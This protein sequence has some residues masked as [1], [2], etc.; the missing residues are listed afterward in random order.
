M[1]ETRSNRKQ[2]LP[3]VLLPLVAAACIG[4][5]VAT[6]RPARQQPGEITGLLVSL[7]REAGMLIVRRGSRV[8]TFH[9]D[10]QSRFLL[11]QMPAKPEWFGLRRKVQ[12]RYIRYAAAGRSVQQKLATSVS[13]TAIRVTG[14]IAR[15]KRRY[16]F[17]RD[18]QA[19][20]LT[21]APQ[22]GTGRA[23]R[24]SHATADAG[25]SQPAASRP[26][27]HSNRSGPAP[28]PVP[29]SSLTNKPHV[30]KRR[31]SA[32]T[33]NGPVIVRF[34]TDPAAEITVDGKPASLGALRRLLN[35]LGQVEI[36]CTPSRPWPIALVIRASTAHAGAHKGNDAKP[37]H[38]D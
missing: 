7:N 2:T 21:P 27:G 22:P 24:A 5:S 6:S 12:V 35:R 11:G 33:E 30:P 26:A 17:L 28:V 14:R 29:L 31:R 10:E 9:I 1:P 34:V 23:G 8:Y 4:A 18:A 37:R 36:I 15:I 38:S 13:L 19:W 20:S 25:A 16:I 3:G 32:S